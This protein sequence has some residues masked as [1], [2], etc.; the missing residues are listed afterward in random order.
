[1][2]CL[3]SLIEWGRARS[4]SGCVAGF[5]GVGSELGNWET[6]QCRRRDREGMSTTPA[7]TDAA[8]VAAALGS[9]ASPMR[10]APVAEHQTP[11]IGRAF[12]DGAPPIVRFTTRT[13]LT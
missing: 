7:V 13:N 3:L 4:T 2:T 11:R 8:L 6:K 12:R 5:R 10:I 9:G 1:M